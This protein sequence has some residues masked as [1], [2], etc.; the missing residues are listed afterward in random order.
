MR[1]VLLIEDEPDHR[2]LVS[3]ALKRLEPPVE[4]HEAN[5]A[6]EAMAWIVGRAKV[7]RGLSDGVVILD[8]GLPG[9][10]GFEFLEWVRE[11]EA[12]DRL[13]VVVLTA[14]ENTMD[15][16]HAFNLGAR[17]YYQKPADFTDYVEILERIMRKASRGT[18]G[19]E[20]P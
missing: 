8:L 16:E 5:D 15:A 3:E 17:G 7:P 9:P 20:T 2:L 4:F 11:H 19:R 1:W 12:L 18:N 10:S 6:S 13:P 14:S